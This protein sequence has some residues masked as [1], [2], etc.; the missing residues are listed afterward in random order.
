[1]RSTRF[2]VHRVECPVEAVGVDL[3]FKVTWLRGLGA[4]GANFS[5]PGGVAAS[6]PVIMNHARFLVPDSGRL[7]V[8][9]VVGFPGNFL[10]I[11]E[12]TEV[13]V[14]CL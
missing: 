8:V 10:K 2:A 6:A 7:V 3:K 1:M 12:D 4:S 9:H 11:M 5:P 13:R 14:W